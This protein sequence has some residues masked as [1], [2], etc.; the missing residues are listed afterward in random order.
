MDNKKLYVGGIAYA[1]SQSGL[2]QAFGQAGSVVSAQ[3]IIDKMTGRSKGFGFVEMASPEE[4]QAAIDMWNDKELDGRRL[5]V[6]L[7]RPKEDRPRGDAPR[8]NFRKF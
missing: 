2:E 1:T 8:G 7:A 3:I 6:N 4:A 5:T